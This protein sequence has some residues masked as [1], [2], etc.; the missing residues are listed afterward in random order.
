MRGNL[1]S[2][3]GGLESDDPHRGPY[4]GYDSAMQSI[5]SILQQSAELP[6]SMPIDSEP[7]GG[8]EHKLSRETPIKQWVVFA[9]ILSLTSLFLWSY[10]RYLDWPWLNSHERKTFIKIASQ[11]LLIFGPISIPLKRHWKLWLTFVISIVLAILLAA[12]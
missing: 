3:R 10:Q 9:I 12:F 1:K 6:P 4:R 2:L 7:L 5:L 11:L 8:T